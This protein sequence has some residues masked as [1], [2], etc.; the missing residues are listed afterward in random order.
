V[1]RVY[2]AGALPVFQSDSQGSPAESVKPRA[3]WPE[4]FLPCDSR[5][6]SAL[7]ALVVGHRA[8]IPHGN[9]FHRQGSNSPRS[10]LG[11]QRARVSARPIGPSSETDDPKF[12]SCGLPAR[13]DE[14]R[15]GLDTAAARPAWQGVSRDQSVRTTVFSDDPTRPGC[16][17]S[18]RKLARGSGRI[19]APK[20]GSLLTAFCP[21]VP[22]D[23]GLR[24]F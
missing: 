20:L 6:R 17:G 18:G 12:G 21:S 11:S 10:R 19:A 24:L 16:Y 23:G 7:P 9:G 4:G 13:F 15:T 2:A 1:Q 5:P 14:L 3:G 8:S 22:P